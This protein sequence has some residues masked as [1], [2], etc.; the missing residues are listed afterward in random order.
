MGSGGQ[1]RAAECRWSDTEGLRGP[2]RGKLREGCRGQE[3]AERRA[4]EWRWSYVEGRER[5]G[6]PQT[7]ECGA[8]DATE[9][10]W[11]DVEDLGG[12][13]AVGELRGGL[14]RPRARRE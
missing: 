10:R 4:A 12:L 6:R 2:W 1:R 9:C 3:G 11:S 13:R 7:V 8:V 5:R 14:R